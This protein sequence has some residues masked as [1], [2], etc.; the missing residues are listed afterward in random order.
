MWVGAALVLALIGA[1]TWQLLAGGSLHGLGDEVAR[2]VMTLRLQRLATS[3][4]VGVSLAV[5]GVLL[6]SLLRNPLASP[7]ILGPSAG[8]SLAVM[9]AVYG[10]T[11][12]GVSGARAEFGAVTWTAAPAL[13]G[14]LGTLA[15]VY[16]LSQRRGMVDPGAL[17]IVGVIVS[18][19]CGAGIMLVQHLMRGAGLTLGE[20]GL[21]VGAIGDAVPATHLIGVGACVLAV[22][23]VAVWAGRSMDAAAMS[24]DEAHSVGV[25]LGVLRAGL[26]LGAGVLTTCAVVLAGPIGFVGLVCPHAVRLMLGAR[27]VGA[28]GLHRALIVGSALAGATLMIGADALVRSIN[29]GAGR[30]PV[31]IVTALVGGVVFIALARASTTRWSA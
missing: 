22:T 8:A 30:M 23:I 12:A 11:L 18:I 26:F 28:L 2:Q 6:Q 9:I 24:D 14:A 29:L 7:D 21:L 31:G 19:M 13:A 3:A 1:T 17:V 27:G 25:R 4:C 5:G 16:A 20:V 10:V 15:L